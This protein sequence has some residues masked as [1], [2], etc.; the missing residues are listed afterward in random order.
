MNMCA[1]IG[2]RRGTISVRRNCIAPL[3]VKY[4]R[5]A[6]SIYPCREETV[7]DARIRATTFFSRNGAG[8]ALVPI[9][10]CGFPTPT[11]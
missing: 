8:M 7:T 10:T 2:K 3:A 5:W 1:I 11:T 6:A 9:A 4:S